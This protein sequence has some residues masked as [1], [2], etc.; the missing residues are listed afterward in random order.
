[1]G[2]M[3]AIVEKDDLAAQVYRYV[4]YAPAVARKAKAGQFVILRIDEDGE[5]I[6][7]TIADWDPL[8]GTIT[9]F[10]QAV[11]KTTIQ[12]STMHAGDSLADVVGPL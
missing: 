11:G 9:I 5:R 8:K 2:L 4:V 7:I 6:P 12:L 3:F 10:V 1:N